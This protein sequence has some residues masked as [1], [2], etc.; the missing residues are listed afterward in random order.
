MKRIA[1]AILFGWAA[2]AFGQGPAP[3]PLSSPVGSPAATVKE[4]ETPAKPHALT[5]DDLE[6]FLDA[7]ISS[8]IENRNM[9]GVVVGAV[10]DGQVLLTKGYGYADYANKK[11]VSPGETLFRPGSISKLFTATAVMQL[12]EQ[13]KLDL[14]RD[15]NEYI[16]FAIPKTYAEPVTLRRLLTH[17]GGF[18]ETLKNLFVPAASAMRPLRDYLIGSMPARIFPPGKVPSYS[19][20]GVALA[21]YIVERAS[22]EK[23]A[24]YVDAHILRPLQMTHST[25]AQPLP[26]PIASGV[27]NGYNF[28][29]GKPLPFE[30]VQAAPAGALSATANDMCQFMLAVLGK[31]TLGGATIL[32]PGTVQQMLSRQFESHAALN[33]I[34]LVFMQYDMNGIGAWGHGGD[35]IAFHSD[36]WIV[37]DA[38]FGFFIS[39]NSAAPKAGGGRGEVMRALF[40]RYFPAPPPTEADIDAATARADAREVS[41]SYI[42]SRRS[43]TS[44]LKVTAILGESGVRPNADGT[45]SID[46]SKNLRG[47][48][49]RWREISPLV[50]REVD[51]P[52]KLAFRK[53]ASGRVVEMLPQPAVFEAQRVPWFESKTLLMPVVGG[54]I[55]ILVLTFLLWPVAAIVRRRYDRPLFATAG[56]RFGFVLV[57]LVC[58]C[59]AIWL[60][61][62][63]MLGSRVDLDISL[64]GEGSN[65]WLILVHVLG[66]IIAAGTLWTVAFAIWTWNVWGHGWWLRVHSSLLALAAVAFVWFVWHCHLL[67]PSLKF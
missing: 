27:S 7:L 29:T 40:N 43:E 25:F 44:F 46:T 13:G 36:L 42:T 34:G 2:A 61:T 53:D 10:K 39:Y 49:K 22:G 37:P 48:L 16:D 52:D 62:V 57:R 50:F 19:N 31:G 60:L 8:Q 55:A 26:S 24:D 56:A 6:A 67:D 1:V 15:V 11:A 38:N 35:T 32:K 58:A 33:A 47:E 21:G 51:G 65:P 30:F 41:G 23:F 4:I 14:D 9:A 54:S 28:A 63:F 59:V 3:T 66:W 64:L 5:R 12:V 18:E 20:W 45:I 17:T